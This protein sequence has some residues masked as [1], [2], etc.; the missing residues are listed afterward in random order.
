MFY[1]YEKRLWREGQQEIKPQRLRLEMEAA[2][3]RLVLKLKTL[4]EY[5]TAFLTPPD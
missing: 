3:V 5:T 2:A 1:F 4:I